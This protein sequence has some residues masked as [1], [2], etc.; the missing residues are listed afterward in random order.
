MA[1]IVV[2]LSTFQTSFFLAS[3]RS[4][5][6]SFIFEKSAKKNVDE[7]SSRVGAQSRIEPKNVVAF[8]PEFESDRHVVK[9][10]GRAVNFYKDSLNTV[11]KIEIAATSEEG[12]DLLE[13]IEQYVQE[14]FEWD[15]ITL[16]A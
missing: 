5:S 1:L 2:T 15:A 9:A 6:L 8:I 14:Y 3:F 7:A 11:K 16:Q 10:V 4:I 12:N 13:N